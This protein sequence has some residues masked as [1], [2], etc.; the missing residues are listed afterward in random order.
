MAVRLAFILIRAQGGLESEIL[1]QLKTFKQITQ[2]YM[3][4]GEWDIIAIAEYEKLPELNTLVLQ[5]RG[6]PG[7][8]QTSTLVVS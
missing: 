4:Y 2:S 3:I 7:V 6:I 8:Q 5:I 1:D